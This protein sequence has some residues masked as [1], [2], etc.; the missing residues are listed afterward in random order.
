MIYWII[1]TVVQNLR[2]ELIVQFLIFYLAYLLSKVSSF[3][4]ANTTV[5]RKMLRNSSGKLKIKLDRVSSKWHLP[6]SKR[7]K[8]K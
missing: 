7:Q 1:W 8:I 2:A 4:K 6:F 5:F 3:S